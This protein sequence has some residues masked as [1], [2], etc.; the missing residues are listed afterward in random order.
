[1][2]RKNCDFFNFCDFSKNFEKLEKSQ[3]LLKLTNTSVRGGRRVPGKKLQFLRFLQKLR[4]IG[5]I[6]V[7]AKIQMRKIGEIA[8]FAKIGKL[9]KYLLLYDS[10]LHPLFIVD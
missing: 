4:K 6:S 3:F 7:F 2:P 5:E 10:T 9:G 1:M 8:G